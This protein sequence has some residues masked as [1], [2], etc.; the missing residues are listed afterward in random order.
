MT[1]GRLVNL[2]SALVLGGIIVACLGLFV[3]FEA[4]GAWF[5][6]ALI[7]AGSVAVLAGVVLFFV[8]ARRSG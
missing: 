7:A 5:G 6:A 2:T 4:G 8:V 3:T 1:T